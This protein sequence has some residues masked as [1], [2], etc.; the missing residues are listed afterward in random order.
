M[1]VKDYEGDPSLLL[2]VGDSTDAYVDDSGDVCVDSDDCLSSF[3]LHCDVTTFGFGPGDDF[4]IALMSKQGGKEVPDNAG[5]NPLS[6]SSYTVFVSSMIILPK[7][8]L[9]N[10]R[11]N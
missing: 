7:A 5:V 11:L 1:S 8:A 9:V 2:T 3:F 6:K 4:G 10:V